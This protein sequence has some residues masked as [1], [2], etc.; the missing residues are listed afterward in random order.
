MFGIASL[1][2]LVIAFLIPDS[3]KALLISNAAVAIAI[4]ETARVNHKNGS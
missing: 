3:N 2:L 1:V 4:L